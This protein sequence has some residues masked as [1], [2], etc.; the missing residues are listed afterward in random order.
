MHVTLLQNVT[1]TQHVQHAQRQMMHAR[2]LEGVHTDSVQLQC[3]SREA[4]P[5][6]R[7]HTNQAKPFPLTIDLKAWWQRKQCCCAAVTHSQAVQPGKSA[8]MPCHSDK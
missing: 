4:H 1:V 3:V 6:D 2:V 5:S 7:K 8:A